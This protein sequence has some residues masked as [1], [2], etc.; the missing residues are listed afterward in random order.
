MPLFHCIGDILY[1]FLYVTDKNVKIYKLKITKIGKYANL[2]NK[3]T[4][5]DTGTQTTISPNYHNLNPLI[6]RRYQYALRK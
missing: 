3:Q 4:H 5:N 1:V 6:S 2:L